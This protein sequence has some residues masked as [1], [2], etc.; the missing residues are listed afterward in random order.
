MEDTLQEQEV[1]TLADLEERITRAVQA[2][3]NL[4]NDNHQLQERLRGTEAELDST[5]SSRDE[6]Q[7]LLEEFQKENGELTTQLNQANEELASLRG[8]RKQVRSR[9][10]KLLGQL[11]SLSM[12]AN[13][14]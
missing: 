9:I 8:E 3:S 12:S 13:A 2:I 11:D 7:G 4:R 1:D 14:S 10:E 6:T 5:R